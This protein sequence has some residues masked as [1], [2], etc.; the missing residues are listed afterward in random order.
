MSCGQLR[1]KSMEHKRRPARL[2]RHARGSL[3]ACVIA[4]WLPWA[5]TVFASRRCR[6]QERTMTNRA[7]SQTVAAAPMPQNSTA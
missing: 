2:A 6:M 7:T 4:P 3:L 5:F 1:S